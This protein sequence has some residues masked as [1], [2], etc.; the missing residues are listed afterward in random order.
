MEW[1]LLGSAA[2]CLHRTGPRVRLVSVLTAAQL[3][4]QPVMEKDLCIQC[5]ACVKC[6][7]NA[8]KARDDKYEDFDVNL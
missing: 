1:V 6:S 7:K 4:G 5:Q 3:E 8:L 2:I